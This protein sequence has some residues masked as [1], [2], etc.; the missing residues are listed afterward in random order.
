MIPACATP[1]YTAGM[2]DTL[3]LT[4]RWFG[5]LVV[6][7]R[8]RKSHMGRY[9]RELWLCQCA[10]GTTPVVRTEEL[11]D[12]VTTSCGTCAHPENVRRAMKRDIANA[13]TMVVCPR[14][15]AIPSRWRRSLGRPA[16]ATAGG[17][18][19]S[20]ARPSGSRRGANVRRPRGKKRHSRRL[21]D[22]RSYRFA[23]IATTT[24]VA[25]AG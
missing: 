5:D 18:T 3:D 4:G 8:T 12:G 23:V 6:P 2:T 10:C 15:R 16:G 14:A 9:P 19:A 1:R 11:L 22:S 25:D 21:L 24:A 17:P 13:E 20:A 7:S